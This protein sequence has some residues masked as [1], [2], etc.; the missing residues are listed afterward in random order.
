MGISSNPKFFPICIRVYHSEFE[1]VASAT[2]VE[3]L[4]WPETNG[5]IYPELGGF[6]S[7]LI[8]LCD[9]AACY[10]SWFTAVRTEWT[11]Q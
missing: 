7:V 4:T 1:A 6:S 3:W 9:L 8:F 5:S 10:V 11:A 2:L